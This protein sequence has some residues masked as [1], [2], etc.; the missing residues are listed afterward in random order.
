M[1]NYLDII[2]THFGFSNFNDFT[3]SIV[4]KN[5]MSRTIPYTGILTT[6]GYYVEHYIGLNS[7]TMVA[8]FV[9]VMTELFTG[10]I[11][12]KK[13][14]IRIESRKFSRFGL[15]LMV[16]ISLFF[17][18][19]VFKMEYTNSSSATSGVYEWLHIFIV[20]YVNMEYLISIL[21]NLGVITGKNYGSLIG[22]VKSKLGNI[23]QP[24]VQNLE[25]YMQE[26]EESLHIVDKDGIILWANNKDYLGYE[27]NEYIGKSIR[28]FHRDQ[29][30]IDD[31]LQR[32]L[33]GEN[34]NNYAAYLLCK[35]GSIKRVL[36]TS[37][38]HW[39]DGRFVH[40]RCF[41]RGIDGLPIDE[42]SGYISK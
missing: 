35:D 22:L 6:I 13:R 29:D 18:L 11:A 15:K 26:S 19:N 1:K 36:I 40:T 27:S 25:D 28:E 2:T 17:V 34:L 7:A 32:L 3:S 5:L 30:V 31:I 41:S 42:G 10:I 9:L 4:H 8:F 12:S 14:G 38:G 20:G 23:N 33:K 21:E 16:W 24:G 39:K 37:S